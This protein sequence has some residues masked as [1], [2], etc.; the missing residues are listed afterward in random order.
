MATQIKLR[1]VHLTKASC[2]KFNPSAVQDFI[3]EIGCRAEVTDVDFVFVIPDS[4]LSKF[5]VISA[6]TQF[7]VNMGKKV[8][9][10][11]EIR[12]LGWSES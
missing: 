11:H 1:F 10:S 2:Y 6:Q 7:T 9:T 4:K 5:K 3:T 8:S 12:I